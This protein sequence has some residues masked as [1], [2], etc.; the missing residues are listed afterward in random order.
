MTTAQRANTK[1]PS[2]SARLRNL[3]M[4]WWKKWLDVQ[5]PYRWYL[6][7]QDPKNTLEVGCGI[8]RNLKNLLP[9][10]AIGVDH[11]LTSVEQAR[12]RGLSAFTP[13]EFLNSSH[14]MPESFD[15]LLLSHLLEHLSEKESLSL[16]ETYLPF[17]KKGGQVI[18]I[19]PQEKGYSSD[20]TH[21]RFIDR[22]EM[23]ILF[24]KSGIILKKIESFPF[25]RLF[26]K[27]FTYNETIAI[28]N[29]PENE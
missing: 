23:T 26:G 20:T 8:G 16:L 2:Y 12:A 3:E 10:K 13:E 21:V 7:K 19:V 5:R 25:P 9:L 6:K 29:I 22:K 18:C 14:A 28:G 15:T 24:A 17:L 11:N 4:V 1:N 27:V